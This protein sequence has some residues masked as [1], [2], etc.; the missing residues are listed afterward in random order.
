MKRLLLSLAIL[1]LPCCTPPVFAQLADAERKDGFHE[2][3]NGRNFDGFR[4]SGKIPKDAAEPPNWKVADG[5]VKLSGGGS[6]H[7]ATQWEYDDFD[8]RFEWKALKKGYNGGFFVRSG[9]Q[10]NAHQINLAQNSCGNLMSGAKGGAGVP[11][12]QK[13]PGEWNEWR[14]LA[15]G[16]KLTFWCNGKQAWEVVGFKAPRGY[17]G[18]QA[19][20]AALDFRNFRVKEIGFQPFPFAN[21]KNWDK[22]DDGFTGDSKA[23]PLD[24][25][26][27][28]GA[29]TLRCEYKLSAKGKATVVARGLKLNLHG[30]DLAK[31]AHPA[32]EWNF[33]EVVVRRSEADV[34]LNG[35]TTKRALNGD[36]NRPL[37]FNVEDGTLQVRNARVRPVKE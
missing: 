8:A 3:F 27:K 36:A 5:L 22:N 1:S 20:G 12:L 29:C 18:W 37:A 35:T 25:A 4:F 26:D 13:P 7:L 30:D 31:A 11:D 2:L 33:L 28:F 14:L 23:G 32:K 15:A 10:V 16:D 6:P 24:S 21:P 17:L 34:W 19:E 9:R